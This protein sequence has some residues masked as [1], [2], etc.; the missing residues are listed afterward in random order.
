MAA[1]R[2]GLTHHMILHTFARVCL[3][4]AVLV[5]ACVCVDWCAYSRVLTVTLTPGCEAPS[6]SS[7]ASPMV[8]QTPP[9]VTIACTTSALRWGKYNSPPY[10][11]G[12]LRLLRN[13][14]SLRCPSRRPRGL[15]RI[16][17]VCGWGLSLC[18]RT[19]DEVERFWCLPL[20]LFRIRRILVV[21]IG[22]VRLVR[23][24]TANV[25]VKKLHDPRCVP[26]AA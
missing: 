6:A 7:A 22:A 15:L 26:S 14:L 19:V 10:L 25:H 5:C 4:V 17:L 16:C 13:L 8:P 21:H 3:F 2:A 20:L 18:R 12:A 1:A 11:D 24:L 9:M 23:R